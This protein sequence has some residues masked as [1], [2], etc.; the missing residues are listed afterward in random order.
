LDNELVTVATVDGRDDVSIRSPGSRIGPRRSR[1]HVVAVVGLGYVGLPTSLAF[2]EAGCDVVGVDIDP[3]RLEAIRAGEVDLLPSDRERLPRALGTGPAGSN[4]RR[5]GRL[6]LTTSVDRLPAADSVLICVPTP[7]DAHLVPELGALAG[8]CRTVAERA[9]RNQL[10][11]VTSTSYAGTTRDLLIGPLVRR[12]L[13]PGQDVFVAFAPERID[14]ANGAFPQERVP[15]IVGGA[16]AECGRRAAR[17]LGRIAGGVHIVG[18]PEAAELAKLYENTFRAVNISLANEL[19]DV[20]GVL[21][22]DPIEVIDA[23]ATKPYGFMPFYPGAGVG[24]HC[25]PVDPHYLL[26]QLR[27][28]G[29][30]LP[31]VEQAMIQIAARP[32]RTAQRV[33]DGLATAGI[34][35]RGTRALLLGVAYKPGVADARMS[36]AIEIMARLERVGVEV[37]FHDPFVDRLTLGGRVRRS[38]ALPPAERYDA[39]VLH[40][41]H[42]GMDPEVVP[43]PVR[44]DCT[45]RRWSDAVDGRL[46]PTDTERADHEVIDLD[47]L[48]M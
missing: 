24:G 43:A 29:V 45:F 5:R 12:G 37:A 41:P 21:G 20:C 7:V 30:N 4:G 2:A 1:R 46:L 19:A 22:A 31:V 28:Q 6:S 18:T 40:T 38:V 3:G 16:T 35:A 47:A 9:R 34:A 10:I 27:A 17:L 23:A 32:A 26:W 8:A 14:P 48:G 39:V 44:V 42:P 13:T 33:L 11:V 36:P 25:I 15:R